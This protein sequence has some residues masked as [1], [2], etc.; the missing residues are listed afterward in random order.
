[1]HDRRNLDPSGVIGKHPTGDLVEPSEDQGHRLIPVRCFS[2][3][4]ASL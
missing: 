1:M 4:M 2:A 3:K